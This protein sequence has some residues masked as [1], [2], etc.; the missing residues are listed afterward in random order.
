MAFFTKLQV[1]SLSPQTGSQYFI[2]PN[3]TIYFLGVRSQGNP[4]AFFTERQYI[5]MLSLAVTTL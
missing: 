3:P 5:V 2:Q 1:T 4:T